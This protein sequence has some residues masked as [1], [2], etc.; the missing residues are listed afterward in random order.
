MCSVHENNFRTSA[1]L[2]NFMSLYRHTTSD[3]PALRQT[4][5]NGEHCNTHSSI[6]TCVMNLLFHVLFWCNLIMSTVNKPTLASMLFCCLYFFRKIVI[7]SF[8]ICCL[9]VF[10]LRAT[11]QTE[12]GQRWRAMQA[13]PRC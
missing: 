5:D 8:V 13:P 4:F 2:L 1:I 10:I 7:I 12:N 3:I 6:V 9:L 11:S